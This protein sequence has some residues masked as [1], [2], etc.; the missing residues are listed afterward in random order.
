[1]PDGELWG[2]NFDGMTLTSYAGEGNGTWHTEVNARSGS[3]DWQTVVG[4]YGLKIEGEPAFWR[5]TGFDST[6]GNYPTINL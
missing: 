4:L 2:L 6:L 1:M 3:Y 5:V